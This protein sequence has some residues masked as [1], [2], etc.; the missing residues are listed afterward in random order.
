MSGLHTCSSDVFGVLMQG[1]T[2]SAR[3]MLV[4]VRR[5]R[6]LWDAVQHTQA[7]LLEAVLGG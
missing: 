7:R 6:A 1:A 3:R 4:V 2:G 5:D